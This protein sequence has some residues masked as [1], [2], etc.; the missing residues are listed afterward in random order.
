MQKFK[1]FTLAIITMLSVNLAWGADIVAYTLTPATGSNNSYAGNCD[2]TI[3]GITWNLTGNSQQIPWRLGGKKITDEVRPLYSKSKIEDNI[4]KIVVTYGSTFSLTSASAT[5]KVYSTASAA[6]SGGDTDLIS[7]VS[8]GSISA[9]GVHTFNRPNGHD[10]TGRYYRFEFTCTYTPN[11]NS[12]FQFSN[13]KFYKADEPTYTVTAVSND[14]NLGTVSGTTTTITASPNECVGYD[15]PAYTVAPAGK[16]TVAQSGN[17]F[18]VSNVTA[19]VTVTINFAELDKKDTYVDNLHG[20]A[21][22]EKCGSYEAPSLPDA[23]KATTGNCDVVHYHFAGWVIGTI[24]TGTTD[25]P[26]GMITA[27]TAM[28]ANKTEYIAVWAKEQ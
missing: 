17:T 13:A 4:T 23:A 12:F 19:D 27:G 16:A 7:T 9:S 2:V 6:E 1:F 26:L 10:W 28:N 21:T 14:E 24:S 8:G 22:I 25:A 3:D 5:L 18:T 20:N 15:D 11:S